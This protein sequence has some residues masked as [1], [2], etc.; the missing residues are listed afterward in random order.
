MR[1]AASLSFS[2]REPHSE[3]TSSMKMMEG[4][5]CLAS[6][7][8]FFTSLGTKA[9]DRV[10]TQGPFAAPT[11]PSAHDSPGARSP[12][13]RR[14]LPLPAPATLHWQRGGERHAGR[15]AIPG[16]WSLRR[17]RAL[18]GTHYLR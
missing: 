4:L 15:R 1:R 7:K 8:R 10:P 16:L 17:V 5:C 3:S 12:T 6:S 13:H 14:L 18:P 2:L 9:G 11:P